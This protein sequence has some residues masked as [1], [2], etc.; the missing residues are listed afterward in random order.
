MLARCCVVVVFPARS[1]QQCSLCCAIGFVQVW[2]RFAISNV[3]DRAE[4]PLDE[5]RAA[6]GQVR[7]P[8]PGRAALSVWRTTSRAAPSQWMCQQAKRASPSCHVRPPPPP[9]FSCHRH[10]HLMACALPTN[11]S[12]RHPLIMRCHANECSSPAPSPAWLA[13]ALCRRT[14][15]TSTRSCLGACLA[16]SRT[17]SR[18]S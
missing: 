3:R 11:A 1:S 12:C 8:V 4:A 18:S 9:P 7:A 17:T 14:T 2:R 16:L 6:Y 5:A 15:A 13:V 10:I